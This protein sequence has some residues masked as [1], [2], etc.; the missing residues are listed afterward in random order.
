MTK[1]CPG[2]EELPWDSAHFG[3]RV[4]R[5]QGE[6]ASAG[7]LARLLEGAKAAGMDLVYLLQTGAVVPPDELLR[8]FGGMRASGYVRFRL[9]LGAPGAGALPATTAPGVSLE[10]Y[11]GDAN[12]PDLLAL[13]IAAGWLSRFRQ[14]RRL[15]AAK[16]D[17]LYEIWTRRSLL[18]E[19]AAE[20]LVARM[21]G[22]PAGLV[23]YKLAEPTAEIGLVGVAAAARGLGLGTAL[24]ALAHARMRAR[25]LVSAEVVTQS[26]NEA[27]CRLYRRAGYQPAIEGAYYHFHLGS[28]Q[29]PSGGDEWISR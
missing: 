17:E 14:D 12:D 20:T 27:A 16:C 25:G 6:V 23:T 3:R 13:G 1:P 9:D 4:A 18:G 29:A 5:I 10:V 26:E 15:P 11:Q 28:A 19:L 21:A 2:V 24:L 8:R 7:E 22:V